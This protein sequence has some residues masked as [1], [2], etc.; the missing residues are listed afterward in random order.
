LSDATPRE[1]GRLGIEDLTDRTNA[2]FIQ[3]VC[4]AMKEEARSL[5]VIRVYA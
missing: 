5:E 1:E 2:A 4:K 3:M